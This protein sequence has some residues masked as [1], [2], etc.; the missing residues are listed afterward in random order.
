MQH[1]LSEAAENYRRKKFLEKA[2]KAFANL[3]RDAKLWKDEVE[4]RK[5]WDNTYHDEDK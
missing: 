3:Q 1:I 2:N 4:E 5:I